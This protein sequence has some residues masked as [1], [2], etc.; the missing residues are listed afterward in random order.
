VAH[1]NLMQATTGSYTEEGGAS[2]FKPAGNGKFTLV[3]IIH[4]GEWEDL[5]RAAR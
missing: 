5:A 3:T 1:G 2:I 4:P